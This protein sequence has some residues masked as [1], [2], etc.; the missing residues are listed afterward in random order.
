MYITILLLLVIFISYSLLIGT[1][2]KWWN[3]LPLFTKGRE[4]PFTKVT[5]IVPARN[6]EMSIAACIRSILTQSYP[7][8]LLE[9][10]IVDDHS[11]DR[12]AAIV[13]AFEKEG[14]RLLRLADYV[15]PGD[16]IVSYKKKAI[17]AAVS[18]A[19]GDL[20]VTT[21]ADC[22]AGPEWISTIVDFYQTH[23]HK[24]IAAPVRIAGNRSP[25]AS[26]QSL[27]FAVLQG[28]TAAAVSG[29]LHNMCNGANLA[30]EKAA[31]AAVNGFEG[32]DHIASGD[33]MLLME[34]I[35]VKFPGKIGYLN[36]TAAMVSSLPVQT[37]TCFFQQRIRWA[38]KA[39]AYKSSG[40]KLALVVVLLVNLSVVA[41]MAAGTVSPLWFR[42]FWVAVFYKMLIEWRFVKQVLQFF[43]LRRLLPLFVLFQPLHALYTVVA[44]FAGL[45]TRYEWKGRRVR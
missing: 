7:R 4:A 30:Y 11:E 39:R 9:L 32:V 15:S 10:I 1:Y 45:F 12:T 20:V 6:E 5:V 31:F 3:R 17:E 18:E 27:D 13:A 23:H 36:S 8:Q 19:K 22:T 16:R 42:V 43:S 40:I 14:V 28:I 26:F 38:S 33:D 37:L 35:A 29:G 2:E 44:G 34:K 21:D 41:L 24:L 25:F